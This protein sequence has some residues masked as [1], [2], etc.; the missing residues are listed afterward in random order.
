[1]WP[2]LGRYALWV[3]GSYAATLVLLGLLVW[4]S[5]ARARRV[6]R[7]LEALEAEI[8]ARRAGRDAS[9]GGEPQESR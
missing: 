9:R 1:M 8:A 3:I 4:V 6:R 7:E 2:D 5:L